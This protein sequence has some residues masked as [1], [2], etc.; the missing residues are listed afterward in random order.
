MCLVRKTRFDKVEKLHNKSLQKRCIYK[1]ACQSLQK[2]IKM[3]IWYTREFVER[4]SLKANNSLVYNNLFRNFSLRNLTYLYFPLQL[5][6][7]WSHAELALRCLYPRY[8][9]VRSW[10][11]QSTYLSAVVRFC[12]IV[13][14]YRG[15]SARSFDPL[16]HQGCDRHSLRPMYEWNDDYR[17]LKRK[18]K[19]RK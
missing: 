13:A 9:M 12:W 1:Y 7:P 4:N 2:T 18:H 3:F 10:P 5:L 8:L 14:Q 16:V 19:I 6:P 11:R 17:E 15:W